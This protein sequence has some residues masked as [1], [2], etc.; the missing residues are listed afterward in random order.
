[1]KAILLL[2]PL[3]LISVCASAQTAAPADAIY[4]H[5][6]ILTGVDLESAQP[7][8]VSAIA[9]RGGLVVATGSDADVEKLQGASTKMADLGGKFVMPGFNDAHAHLGDAGRIKLSVDVTGTKS[10]A[11]LQERVQRLDGLWLLGNG[12]RG[13][14]LPDL[15][16]DARTAVRRFVEQK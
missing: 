7:Q 16:R 15:V 6:N 8:R 2:F 4:F 10:L 3:L 13:V 5:G 1:M 9:V 14:G 12:Y 11:E